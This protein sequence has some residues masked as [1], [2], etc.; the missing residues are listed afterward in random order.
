MNALAVTAFLIV[1]TC[2]AHFQQLSIISVERAINLAGLYP[3]ETIKFRFKANEDGVSRFSYLL[4]L[5]YD[6]KISLIGFT[7]NSKDRRAF[8]FSRSIYIYVLLN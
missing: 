3:V 1:L 6:S 8:A 4:P 5:E 7:R 2:S